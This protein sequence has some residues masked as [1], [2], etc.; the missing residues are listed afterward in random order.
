MIRV[1]SER[2]RD[3]ARVAGP[4]AAA[5][6]AGRDLAFATDSY[7]LATIVTA[8]LAAEARSSSKYYRRYADVEGALTLLS[9]WTGVDFAKFDPAQVIQHV[10]ND[11]GRTALENVTRAD[12]SRRLTVRRRPNML[13]SAASGP[14]SARAIPPRS[15]TS[16]KPWVDA[17]GVDGFNLAF[18]VRPE[19][20]ED[21]VDWIVPER[22]GAAAIGPPTPRA[23]CARSLF[24]RLLRPSPHPGAAHR[25]A[26]AHGAVADAGSAPASPA[27]CRRPG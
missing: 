1:R 7:A 15:P 12:P 14:S 10:E 13:R 26:A 16:S 25:T 22:Q 27:L 9:G 18:A 24:V 2:D 23:R 3:R 20:F 8:E 19:T 4:R 11:A 21:V 5:A 6:A 17:T